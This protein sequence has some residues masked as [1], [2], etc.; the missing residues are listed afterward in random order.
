MS[1]GA[2]PTGHAGAHACGSPSASASQPL[3][4]QHLSAAGDSQAC[5]ATVTHKTLFTWSTGYRGHDMSCSPRTPTT[6]SLGLCPLNCPP[7][8]FPHEALTLQCSLKA[9]LSSSEDRLGVLSFGPACE[10]LPI[11]FSVCATSSH[12][13]FLEGEGCSLP[14]PIPWSCLQQ[15]AWSPDRTTREGRGAWQVALPWHPRNSASPLL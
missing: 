13:G 2:H 15:H 14:R 6:H 1:Q 9:R 10:S 5:Q 8:T 4:E 7:S 3:L 11:H 12:P